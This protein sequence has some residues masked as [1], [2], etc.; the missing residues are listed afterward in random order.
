[1]G[2]IVCLMGKSSSGKDTIYKRML[3]AKDLNFQT[4]VPYTTRPIRIKERDGVEYH[5]TD[6]A[7]YQSL[8]KAGKVVEERVYETIH[9]PWRYFTVDDGSID[10]KNANYLLVT[11]P[12]GYKSMKEYFGEENMLPIL[13]NVDDGVRLE[14]ALRRERKQEVP[15]YE[16][17]C[18]RFLADS[19]DFAREK[20]EEAG[21]HR[22]FQNDEVLDDCISEILE[23]VRKETRA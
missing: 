9:G 21:I 8:L 10:P 17:M 20:L 1:M 4:I 6:E 19:A 22:G 2:K 15:K 7:G 13:V 14:R 11:T 23:Y 12:A 3:D 18:R 5:F 16:E